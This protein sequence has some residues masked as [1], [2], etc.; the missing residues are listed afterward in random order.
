MYPV[1]VV[2]EM[3]HSHSGCSCSN[4]SIS[5]ANTTLDNW[6]LLFGESLGRILVSVSPENQADFESALT[7]HALYRIGKVESGDS[8]T[9]SSRGE[10]IL[11]ASMSE[12]RTAWKGTLDGGSP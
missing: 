4:S 8:I 2:V 5:E 1:L 3:T 9:F 6:G 12:L 11:S 10:E 7:G